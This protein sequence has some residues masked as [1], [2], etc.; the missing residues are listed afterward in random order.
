M[1]LSKV[2]GAGSARQSSLS[3]ASRRVAATHSA[4]WCFPSAAGAVGRVMFWGLQA[5]RGLEARR[6]ALGATCLLGRDLASERRCA[7]P[8]MAA[9]PA[10][11][12][13]TSVDQSRPAHDLLFARA[14]TAIAAQERRARVGDLRQGQDR[15]GY[16][17]CD[18]QPVSSHASLRLE[19]PVVRGSSQLSLPPQRARGPSGP[20]RTSAQRFRSRPAI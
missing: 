4:R 12:T 17:R 8:A 6:R 15:P 18:H 9:A 20:S 2:G 19:F 13:S 10:R 11:A 14:W 1:V 5:T 3:S 16:K 7:A